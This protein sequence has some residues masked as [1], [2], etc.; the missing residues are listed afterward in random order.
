MSVRVKDVSLR[1]N[2]RPVLE[3]LSFELPPGSFTLLCGTNGSGKSTLLRIL[4]GLERPD[5]GLVERTGDDAAAGA[6]R[7]LSDPTGR[8]PG[9]GAGVGPA[10]VFQQPEN[11]LF[12]GTVARDVAYGLGQRGVPK[13]DQAALAAAALRRTGL[14]PEEYAERSP[15]LLSGGEKRRAAIA[16]ALAVSPRLLLLDEPTAGLDPAGYAG[17][18]RTVA[19]LKAEGVGLV[20]STHDLDRF[21][22][23]AD[24][25]VVLAGGRL[26]YA[27]PA[28]A[29]A[30]DERGILEQAGLT[31]PAYLALGRRLVR[32]G[33]LTA[34]PR[35]EAEL[36]E[37][38][39][40]L[41]PAPP[42]SG[43]PTLPGSG[44]PG[45]ASAGNAAAGGQTRTPGQ[46]AAR[47]GADPIKPPAVF[48]SRFAEPKLLADAGPAGISAGGPASRASNGPAY[49]VG[50]SASASDPAAGRPAVPA[51]NASP[52]GLPALARRAGRPVLGLDPRAKWAA[53][54]LWSLALL[55]ARSWPPLLFMAVVILASGAAAGISRR[56]LRRYLRPAVPMLLLFWLIS[57]VSWNGPGPAIGPLGFSPEGAVSGGLSALRLGL[58]LA[59]G[60]LFTETTTGA[61]LRE[62]MEWAI[63]PLRRIGIPVRN[64]SLV[65]QITLQFAP[66]MLAKLEDLQL[67]LASRGRPRSGPR[68]WSPRQTAMLVTP[69]LIQILTLGDELST[70]I[71][72]RGYD[73]SRPRTP[74]LR[75]VWSPRDTRA[76]LGSAAVALIC[77]ALSR[78]A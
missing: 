28:A 5:S 49:S 43:G 31:P 57:A 46:N 16:G 9:S 18:L 36:L 19:E 55:G 13:R 23:L 37:A 30:E 29:L 25:A 6:A 44:T 56:T 42:G 40:G 67:A 11:Q 62:A 4:A 39:A 45:G 21:L 38:L 3:N 69:L 24:Q 41:R 66:W 34:V 54:L 71:E 60:L 15:Y 35:S 70:A 20:V 10:L 2:G 50:S 61:P 53:L 7:T 74:R 75:L 64:W 14:S 58:L 48:G 59:L 51:E 12:A 1:Y 26:L 32:Q 33:R 63:A 47:S 17:L 27:G 68:R 76:L 77:L 78:L 73:A 52:A 72:S 22:P 65:V 8:Y